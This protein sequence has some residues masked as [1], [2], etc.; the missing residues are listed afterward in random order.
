MNK[1]VNLI[2]I[3]SDI[4]MSASVHDGCYAWVVCGASL[5]SNVLQGGYHYAI[6]VLYI[7]LQEN[8]NANDSEIALVTSLSIGIY[9]VS[10]K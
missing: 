4:M 8:L 5:L 2:F 7:M 9:F 6:G 10:C 1:N 3:D